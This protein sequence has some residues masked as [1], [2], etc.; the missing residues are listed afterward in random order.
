MQNF[1]KNIY[2]KILDDIRIKLTDE[3][4]RN[5]ERQA[6]FSTPWQR[7]KSPQRQDGHILVASGALRRSIKTVSEEKT[8]TFSSSLPYAAIHNE[9]GKIKVTARMKKFFWR[10]YYESIGGF[11]RKKDGGLRKNKKNERLGTLA[12]FYKH[13]ALMKVGAEIKIPKRQ[14][15]GAHPELEEKVT[16]LIERRLEEYFES[17]LRNKFTASYDK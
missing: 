5:F 1:S 8:I 2:A 7:H 9:G 3:F 4:D 11:G 14:F 6:F 10:R 12:E 17:E 15:L 16:E 13:M